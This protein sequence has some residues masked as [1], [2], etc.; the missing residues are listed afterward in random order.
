QRDDSVA[1]VLQRHYTDI[2]VGN[3][4][5][6]IPTK[7]ASQSNLNVSPLSDCTQAT[8]SLTSTTWQTDLYTHSFAYSL[9]LDKGLTNA[10]SCNIKQVIAAYGKPNE[11][12]L[13]A[14]NLSNP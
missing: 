5:R 1:Q 3:Y 2:L 12:S 6:V 14:G 10:P 9:S 13:I 4:W 11:S 8:S 7:L